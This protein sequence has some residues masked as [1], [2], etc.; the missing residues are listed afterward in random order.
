MGPET[1]I[2][3]PFSPRPQEMPAIAPTAVSCLEIKHYDEG[4]LS[5]K[6]R[7][8]ASLSFPPVSGGPVESRPTDSTRRRS[9]N[10]RR[11]MKGGEDFATVCCRLTQR[12]KGNV[13][14]P[15]TIG[16]ERRSEK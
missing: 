9:C 5:S 1:T 4:S 12:K 2:S 8:A 6:R 7:G 14:Y 15:E 11:H 13:P 10:V 16:Q 3:V